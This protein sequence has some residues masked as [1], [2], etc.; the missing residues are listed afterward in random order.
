V[1]GQIEQLAPHLLGGQA[2]EGARRVGADG[3]EGAEQADKGVLQDVLGVDPAADPAVASRHLAGQR[4]EAALE[5]ADQLVA[6]REIA[7]PHAV[8]PLDHLRRLGGGVDHRSHSR[9]RN[10]EDVAK[11]RTADVA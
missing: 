10:S 1:P 6:R 5:R 2:E 3:L 8:E 11:R 4:F 9:C 7:G